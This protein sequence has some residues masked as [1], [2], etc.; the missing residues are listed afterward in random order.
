MARSTNPPDPGLFPKLSD[1]ARRQSR[2]ETLAQAPEPGDIWVFAYGSLMWNPCFE[3]AERAPARLDG[4]ER[5]FNFWTVVARGTPERPGLGLGIEAAAGECHG[6]AYRLHSDRLEEEGEAI[7]ERE[8]YS[9]VYRPRWLSIDTDAGARPA[10]AFVTVPGH[11]QYAPGLTLDEQAE[12]IARAHG[13]YGPCSEYLAGVVREMSR[14]GVREPELERLKEKVDALCRD[15][16][17]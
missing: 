4:Y 13:K 2:E 7:W 17:P 6:I 3:P 9:G 15:V 8:M 14:L 11:P 10:L 1:D 16:N 12:I 5:R